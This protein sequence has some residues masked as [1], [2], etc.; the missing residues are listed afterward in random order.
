MF[1]KKKTPEDYIAKKVYKKAISMYRERLLEQSNNTALL[2]NVADTLLLDKQVDE[3]LKEYKKVA[4]IY[5]EQGFIVK[6][7]AIYKRML[8]LRPGLSEIENLMAN[9]SERMATAD[10]S[11]VQPAAKLSEKREEEAVPYLEI[12]NKL[13]KDLRPEE[14]KQIVEKL[15]LRHFEEDTIVVQEGDPGDSLFIVE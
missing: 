9:L 10:I 4:D 13:L 7:I 15:N 1:W 3:A 11:P 14:F 8:K 12:E 5:T 2:M 6:A